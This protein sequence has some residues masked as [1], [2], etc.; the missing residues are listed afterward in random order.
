MV[1]GH[2]PDPAD[3]LVAAGRGPNPPDEKYTF[4]RPSDLGWDQQGNIFVADG[5]CNNRVVK[6]DKNGR[7]IAP[8]RRQPGPA[9]T[10]PT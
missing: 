6:Y 9:A 10:M 5:Y 4:C 8:V 1:M 2:R 7:Y 3:G